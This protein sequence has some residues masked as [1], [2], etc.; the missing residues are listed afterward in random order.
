MPVIE[1]ATPRPAS[2]KGWRGG[3]TAVFV[4]L[5]VGV[6][7]FLSW[8]AID[9]AMWLER[10]HHYN[11]NSL[12]ISEVQRV[13]RQNIIIAAGAWSVAAVGWTVIL[14]WRWRSRD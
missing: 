14:G 7:L 1:Y 13:Q 6:C 8:G 10:A 3:W 11:E 12:L 5:T 9:T 4:C 2:R